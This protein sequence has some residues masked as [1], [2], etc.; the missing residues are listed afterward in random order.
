MSEHRKIIWMSF[1]WMAPIV[2]GFYLLDK[3]TMEAG[4][5]ANAPVVW[6]QGSALIRSNDQF[7]LVLLIHPECPCSLATVNELEK[8]MSK[9]GDRLKSKVLV[10]RASNDL[11]GEGGSLLRSRLSGLL[12]VE[13]STDVEGQEAKRFGSFTSGQALLYN[14]EGVLVFSGGITGSRGHEGDNAGE[15]AI[16]ELINHRSRALPSAPVYGCELFQTTQTKGTVHE[17]RS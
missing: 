5:S 10:Y 2:F 7:N 13:I 8:L 15:T 12:N 11:T 6:P 16:I 9:S 3:H 4:E 14:A 17:A 1:A